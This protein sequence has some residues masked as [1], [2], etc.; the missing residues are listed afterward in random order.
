MNTLSMVPL[1]MG[2]DRHC[3]VL[4]GKESF[5]VWATW[6]STLAALSWEDGSLKQG[7]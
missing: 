3:S 5:L 6:L 4:T 1:E 7:I 2:H